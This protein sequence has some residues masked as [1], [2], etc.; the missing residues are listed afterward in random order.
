MRVQSKTY[1]DIKELIFKDP[2]T[3][4]MT[5]L[6]TI[7]LAIF[8]VYPIILVL[9]KSVFVDGIVSLGLY[10]DFFRKK[11][12]YRALINSMILACVVTPLTVLLSFAFAYMVNRGPHF[13]RKF[14]RFSALI[15][16]VTPPFVFALALI[17]LGGRQ[18]LLSKFFGIDYSLFGWSG[19][20][21]AQ[22]LHFI[23]LCFIMLDSV[24]NSLNPNLDEAS[25]ILGGSQTHTLFHVS[26][27]LCMPGIL[28]S[29]L[30]VF[31]L[32]LA[33]FGNPALIGGGLPF[34]ASE[35][36]ILVIGQYDLGMASVYSIMLLIPSVILYIFHKYAIR[37]E[38]Y[39]TVMGAPGQREEV[40]VSPIIQI[41]MLTLCFLTSLAIV[42]IFV[43]IVAGAFTRIIGINNAFTMQHF[44]MT[45]SLLFFKNSLITSFYAA[46]IGTMAG[47]M[48]AYFIMR[49][50]IPGKH[51]IE[52]TSLLGFA[53]PG[54]IIGIGYILAFNKPPLLLSGT[55]TI[56]VLTMISRTIAV[57]VEAGTAKLLQ[58][59]RSIEEASHTLGA[60]SANTFY[61]ITLPLMF[62]AFFGSMIYS[63][64]H[65]MNTLSAV[66]FV[67]SPR[68]MIA[69]VAIFQLASEG[70]IGQ[71]CALS[72]F[73]IICVFVS[74]L[75]MYYVLKRLGAKG[76]Q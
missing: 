21:L 37:E 49:K 46:V 67:T 74:L 4:F 53:V 58:L 75:L 57:S 48:L 42:A 47:T 50:T 52:F 44:S 55:M 16:F 61:R 25:G 11:I 38:K 20:I 17:I 62:T 72:I 54:T 5:L 3:A 12:H 63:F 2:L 41:P 56:I 40:R 51:L 60:N 70:R 27:P 15:P 64:I 71:A 9:F 65:S 28:K 35:S 22:V 76:I 14:F 6:L 29:G 30:M 36:Y 34:L 18:G 32:S 31:I 68:Y 23:P 8:I 19:V 39:V 7:G 66:I 13:L 59:D 1:S 69:P 26:I 33:D 43:I 73:L 45:S 10:A 24:M